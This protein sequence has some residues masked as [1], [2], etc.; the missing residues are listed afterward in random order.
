[1]FYFRMFLVTVYIK[2]AAG[3]MYQDA[4]PVSDCYLPNN[5]DDGDDNDDDDDKK[6]NNNNATHAADCFLTS[7]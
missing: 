3:N 6:K 5:Y 2:L 4:P 7:A 1:M